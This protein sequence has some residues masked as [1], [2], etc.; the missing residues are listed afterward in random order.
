MI[1]RRKLALKL[2]QISALTLPMCFERE[3]TRLSPELAKIHRAEFNRVKDELIGQ[4]ERNTGQIW[5]RY[6]EDI[7]AKNGVTVARKAGGPFDA[8]HII[9]SS[10]GG[11]NQWW[12][13]HPAR[14]PD[15]HQG[16]IH[17]AGGIAREI[18]S[19]K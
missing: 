2:R 16:G 17:R 9:E 8:H 13:M 10:Y 4:W 1:L 15:Q 14:F 6:T 19:G 5:P 11:P 12:N 7:L 3:F 18:F